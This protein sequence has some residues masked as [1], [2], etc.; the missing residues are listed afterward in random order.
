MRQMRLHRFGGVRRDVRV[1]NARV[2]QQLLD[3]E[4]IPDMKHFFKKL[5]SGELSDDSSPDIKYRYSGD[6]D[7]SPSPWRVTGNLIAGGGKTGKTTLLAYFTARHC[8]ANPDS[9]VLAVGTVD[10]FDKLPAGVRE[11]PNFKFIETGIPFIETGAERRSAVSILMDAIRPVRTAEPLLIA[12]DDPSLF[13][14]DSS[15]LDSDLTINLV[16][17]ERVAPGKLTFLLAGKNINDL[18]KL[19]G[20]ELIDAL[21]SCTV[22]QNAAE[23][24]GAGDFFSRFEIDQREIPAGAA[25]HFKR[26]GFADGAELSLIEFEPGNPNSILHTGAPDSGI[27]ILDR[28][29]DELYSATAK[30]WEDGGHPAKAVNQLLGI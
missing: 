13:F 23:D 29:G 17:L 16:N 11:N 22:L 12:L 4:E 20:A 10:F 9:H 24:A 25:F 7:Q 28:K 30:Y 21:S 2:M 19:F 27:M 14:E 5:F 1:D 26:R 3:F 6:R 8:T 15:P 18:K